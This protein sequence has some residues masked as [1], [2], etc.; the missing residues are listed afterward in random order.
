MLKEDLPNQKRQ[1]DSKISFIEVALGCSARKRSDRPDISF[2]LENLISLKENPPCR[3]SAQSYLPPPSLS[4]ISQMDLDQWVSLTTSLDSDLDDLT[5][6]RTR[7]MDRLEANSLREALCEVPS[8]GN[9]FFSSISLLRYGTTDRHDQVRK[10]IVTW[11]EGNGSAVSNFI[12]EQTWDDYCQTMAKNSTWADH[13]V[14]HA[15]AAVYRRDIQIISSIAGDEY[16]I[17][18]ES[19]DAIRP[20][21]LLAH[22]H[23]HHYQP[24]DTTRVSSR[25]IS[26]TA[27]ADYQ[28]VP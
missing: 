4:S 13:V 26:S 5:A 1:Q 17:T 28:S 12:Y 23:E 10:D 20:P 25:L 8:D 14:L 16:F 9:C 3:N 15:A 19:P 24:I 22:W 11:L 2:V 7:L 27:E 21:F 18:V 6:H